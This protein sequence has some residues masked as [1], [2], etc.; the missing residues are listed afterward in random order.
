MLVLLSP[1][2]TLD[3]ESPLP[4]LLPTEPIF[5]EE[6]ATL[7]RSL[8]RLK[9]KDL[10]AIMSISENLAELN[11]SRYQ[12]WTTPFTPDNARPALFTFAGDVYDGLDTATLAVDDVCQAQETLRILSGL[13]GLLRPLDLMQPYRLEMGCQFKPPRYQKLTD[14]WTKR[15]TGQLADELR[16]REHAALVNLASNEYAAA[17]DF[18]K[19]PVPVIDVDFKEEKDGQLRVL[20]FFAKK[21][22]GMMARFI[23]Q[24][25]LDDPHDLQAFGAAGY[26][27]RPELSSPCHLIF[28]RPQPPPATP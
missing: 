18:A 19:L 25:K 15:L 22:R 5:I 14:F 2:K 11:H 6:A 24:H 20:S 17:V 28:A 13:Y 26:A 8:R 16:E 7:V 23:V 1:A 4:D 3:L 12:E 10:Q 9:T 27:Y 21:A